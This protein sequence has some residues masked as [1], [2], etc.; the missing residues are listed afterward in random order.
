M[1]REENFVKSVFSV[2][3]YVFPYSQFALL[4]SYIVQSSDVDVFQ[5]CE[6]IKNMIVRFMVPCIIK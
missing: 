2:S 6:V 1:S 4:V 5:F 3:I